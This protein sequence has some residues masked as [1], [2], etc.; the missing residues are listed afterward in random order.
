[1]A[2]DDGRDGKCKEVVYIT[3]MHCGYIEIGT[4]ARV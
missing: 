3:V 2:G 1:M 4:A